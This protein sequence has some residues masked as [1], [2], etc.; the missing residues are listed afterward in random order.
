MIKRIKIFTIEPKKS[1][2]AP[3]ECCNI[4]LRYSVKEKGKHRLR[5]LFQVVNR[6]SI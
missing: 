1:K 3:G 2:L 4:R 6:K 5:V